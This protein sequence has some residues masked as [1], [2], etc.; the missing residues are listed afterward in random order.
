MNYYTDRV[1][2][3]DAEIPITILMNALYAKLH[4]ALWDLKATNIGISFPKYEITLGNVLRIHSTE[5]ALNEL[6]GMDWLGGIKGYCKVGE[7]SLVPTDSKFRTVSRKQSTMSQSKLNRLI[8]RGSIAEGE[9]KEYRAKM[10]GEGLVNPYLELLS[11]SSRNKYRRYIEFGPLL[12]EPVSGSF[13]QF[14]LSKIATV[15]WF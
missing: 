11:S 1:L 4:K 8:K 5:S 15:P 2:L 9:V 13:D 10:V 12:D 3:P 14:G 6:Q 7:I